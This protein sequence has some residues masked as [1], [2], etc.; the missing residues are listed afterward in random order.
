MQM[1]IRVYGS[2]LSYRGVG[3]N[4]G[5]EA[6][7]LVRNAP[8]EGVLA[9]AMRDKLDIGGESSVALVTHLGTPWFAVSLSAHEWLFDLHE[10]VGRYAQLKVKGGSAGNIDDARV[11]IDFSVNGRFNEVAH[12]LTARGLP[13]I[14]GSVSFGTFEIGTELESWDAERVTVYDAEGNGQFRRT[15]ESLSP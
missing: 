14:D 15:V 10:L 4:L 5:K 12:R 8:G 2:G 7:L 13:V 11:S 6:H 1:Q 3:V 9:L